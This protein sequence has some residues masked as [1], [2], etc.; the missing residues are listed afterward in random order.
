MAVLSLNEEELISC[1]GEI[2]NFFSSFFY[3]APDRSFISCL[4]DA[5]FYTLLTSL[6]SNAHL[7]SNSFKEALADIE[8]FIKLAQ[9]VNIEE[10]LTGVG[11]EY[12]RLFRGMKPGYGVCLPYE[13]LYRNG[14]SD[15]SVLQDV[16]KQYNEAGVKISDNCCERYDHLSVE[17]NFISYLCKE[18]TQASEAGEQ[19]KVLNYLAL[20]KKF[21]Q[22]LSE[23]VPT[24]CD[25]VIRTSTSKLLT[26]LVKLLKEFICCYRS[27]LEKSPTLGKVA[28]KKEEIH[29]VSLL[30]WFAG[31]LR[32]F[33][34][35]KKVGS[36]FVKSGDN[37]DPQEVT[38]PTTCGMC[39][40]SC[41]LLA[42]VRDGILVRL[43]GNP[44]CPQ[45]EGK[46]C[47]KGL[48]SIMLLYDPYRLKVPLIRTNPEKGI[49]VDP[50]WREI[51]WEEAVRIVVD[52]L[53]KIKEEDPKK[54]LWCVRSFSQHQMSA[55]LW[56]IAFGASYVMP[57]SAYGSY[58]GNVMHVL[59][60]N[61]RQ[62]FMDYGDLEY[63]EYVV[64]IGGGQG[65]LAG[66]GAMQNTRIIAKRRE[67][68]AKI[69]VVDPRL[70]EVAA[71]AYRW[72][73]ILPGTEAAWLLSLCYVILHEIKKYD[74]EHLKKET[75]AVYL[76]D[77]EGYFVRG[78][79]NNKV[80]IW[81]LSDMKA[82]VIDDPTLKEP[83]L[84]GSYMVNGV[85]CE[86]AFQRFL[87]LVKK[88]TPEATEKITT[89]P[90]SI[91]REVAKELVEHAHIGSV[92]EIDGKKY[93]YRPV[94]FLA[95]SGFNGHANSLNALMALQCL[96]HILGAID[97]VGSSL[98]GNVGGVFGF[99]HPPSKLKPGKDGM[100]APTPA[101]PPPP[102][103]SF[104]VSADMQEYFPLGF[105]V[106]Q[107]ATIGLSAPEKYG[108]K[109]KPEE[110]VLFVAGTNPVANSINPQ[111]VGEVLKRFGY[112]IDVTLYL[113]ETCDFADLVIPDV[114]FLERIT[115]DNFWMGTPIPCCGIHISQPVVK[116]LSNAK[117]FWEFM[118][119]V[120]EK[121]GCLREFYK[122]LN[123]FLPY[124]PI[125]VEK[126][127]SWEEIC[128][129]ICRSASKAVLGEELSFEDLRK[130]GFFAKK[131][132]PELKYRP[133]FYNGLRV[134]FYYNILLETRDMLKQGFDKFKVWEKV[135][136][137]FLMWLLSSYKPLPEYEPCPPLKE[138]STSSDL[139]HA[140]C[141]RPPSSIFSITQTNPI[142]IEVSVCNPY[143]TAV[144]IHEEAARKRGIKDGD[145]I[146]VESKAGK[147]I[148]VAR[149]TQ[150]IHP[151]VI[152][153][154]GIYGLWAHPVSRNV[155]VHFNTLIPG[156]ME[157]NNP[158]SC[159]L[160][161]H[162]AV[163][164]YKAAESSARGD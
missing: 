78:P 95:Y 41:A 149:V 53:K 88:Y 90:A 15:L 44:E 122:I 93:P 7:F 54:L 129:H 65:N 37:G 52:K 135:P 137:E 61:T 47:L 143:W 110:L 163:K 12:T 89:I 114:T 111:F 13:S 70:T 107:V 9:R 55:H 36:F 124:A 43:R 26:G 60:E 38:I 127:H 46:I 115:A 45:N 104:P 19:N 67:D 120:S 131:I 159:D 101:V 62:S 126:F 87:E 108:L 100:N 59:L 17:L 102:G 99:G 51:S 92:I 154:S 161:H 151:N 34:G 76:I 132:P 68:G 148:G 123:N 141:Y 31:L 25:K 105:E 125:E 30:K 22:R 80:M 85:S 21:L 28:D 35:D 18:I 128:D 150:A 97:A 98:A 147:V 27:I 48:S 106:N 117:S 144:Q 139:L 40:S 77:K 6:E 155:G 58:C 71:K 75:N 50:R 113:D 49:G 96:M 103:F 86:P 73:P 14:S 56:P 133:Y 11:V 24:F 152:A 64:I 158:L 145:K 8:E 1:A 57:I 91:T 66:P 119:E 140:I 29:E 153:I 2:F 121:V 42:T 130:R 72:I 94:S 20:K 83:A 136:K 146:V 4:N 16:V 162:V 23:W 142:L 160:E 138:A 3:R 10:T 74:E 118:I 63:S 69:V 157:Y 79:D 112:I 116:P 164:V 156:E 109:Y 81:D 33:D 5:R 84:T 39:Y 134:P 32:V 82:K